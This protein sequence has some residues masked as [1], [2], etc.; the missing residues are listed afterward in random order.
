MLIIVIIWI[1]V[2][3]CNYIIYDVFKPELSK[4]RRVARRSRDA[5]ETVHSA[6]SFCSHLAGPAQRPGPAS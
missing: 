1:I 2:I 4:L 6:S 3:I 5:G